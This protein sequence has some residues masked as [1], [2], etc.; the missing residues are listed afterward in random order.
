MPFCQR[1]KCPLVALC[2]TRH[3]VMIA[4]SVHAGTASAIAMGAQHG[5]IV[6][7]GHGLVPGNPPGV[8]WLW[9]TSQF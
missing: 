1:P 3:E 8:S 2:D 6:P 7:A 5:G 9:E 4:R